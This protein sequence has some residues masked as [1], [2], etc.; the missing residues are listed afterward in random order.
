MLDRTFSPFLENTFSGL[1]PFDQNSKL[2]FSFKTIKKPTETTSFSPVSGL[3][4]TL[5]FV[6][7]NILPYLLN[8][9]IE[10]IKLKKE[11]YIFICIEI[12]DLFE[13]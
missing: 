8:I 9:K 11:H 5:S 4:Y 2:P 12:A 6:N 7:G 10:I 3:K 13:W 1:G